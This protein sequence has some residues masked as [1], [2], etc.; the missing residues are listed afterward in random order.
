MKVDE[1][2]DM[3]IRGITA[4]KSRD[5]ASGGMIDIATITAENG[6]KQIPEEDILARIK[7]LKLNF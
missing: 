5:S 1:A 3:V 7:K 4:A 6:F 2:I